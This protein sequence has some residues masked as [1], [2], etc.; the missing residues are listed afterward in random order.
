MRCIYKIINV[1]NNKFYIGSAVD[2][3]RRKAKHLWRL[4]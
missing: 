1:R 3:K 4:R 2:F